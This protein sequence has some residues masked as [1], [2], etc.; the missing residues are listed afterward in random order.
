MSPGITI[1]PAKKIITMCRSRPTAD[2]VAVRDGRILGAGSLCELAGW[3]DYT[4][5]RRFADSFVM[6]GFVEGHS[7]L[8]EGALWRYVYVGFFDRTAPDGTIWPGL[9]SIDEVVARLRDR[10]CGPGPADGPV[11]GWGFDPIYFSSRRMTAADLDRVAGDRPVIVMHASAHMLNANGFVLE[12]AGITRDTDVHGIVKDEHGL[13]TGELQE[14]AAMFIGFEIAGIDPFGEMGSAQCIRDFAAVAQRAGVTTATDLYAVLRPGNVERLLAVTGEDTCPIRLATAYGALSG[15]TDEGV[16]LMGDLAP[17]STDKLRFGIVKMMTDGSIQ[18]F[19]AR[20][21]WPGYFNGAPNG[22]WNAPPEEL[23]AQFAAYHRAGFQIH[24]HTN[25]DEAIEVMLDAIQAA[26]DA[27]PRRDHRHTLQHCQMVSEAQLER[28]AALGVCV[29]LFANHL[30]YWGE[31]HLGTTLGPERAH[32]LEPLAT[33]E[34]L[35]VRY[36]MHSD[37]PVTPIGPLFTAWCAVERK[38]AA[39]RVLG[40]KERISVD[41]ALRA[42]TLGAAYTL[43]MDHLVGSIESGK[44]ADF[45]VLEEDPLSVPP[46]ALRDIPVRATVLGG[47]EFPAR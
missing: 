36:A 23:K 29:N 4:L 12:A 20:L 21:K 25:G 27:H 32:R 33:A 18:G 3:G 37:A 40:P 47:R 39:G 15:P 30:Y 43:K 45:A 2:H 17:R 26:L 10:A 19:T 44:F 14:L 35:G 24:I 13:P 7:H 46:D 1:F 42:I 34:R 8:L 5:D 11:V 28:A 38:T 41:R 16:A 6:P 9:R 22:I 31:E